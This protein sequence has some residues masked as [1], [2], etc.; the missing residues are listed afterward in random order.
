M[1]QVMLNQIQLEHLLNSVEF[2]ME[3]AEMQ[4]DM[5]ARGFLGELYNELDAMLYE[6]NEKE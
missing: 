4:A 1:G 3:D 6:L 2:D 5:A